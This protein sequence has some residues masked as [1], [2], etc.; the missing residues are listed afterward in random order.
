MD[1]LLI[2]EAI[3]AH[4]LDLDLQIFA[5]GEEALHFIEKLDQDESVAC[6]QLVLLDINLPRADGFEVL[7]HLRHSRRCADIPVIIM[8][9]SA[10]ASDRAKSTALGANAYFQ[11]PADYEAFLKL[12]DVVR[13]HLA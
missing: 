7:G 11:K 8:T 1:V 2:K 5:N 3:V 10:A 12:G 6:P 13:K 4:Q 9:S